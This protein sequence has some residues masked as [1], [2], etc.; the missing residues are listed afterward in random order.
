[1]RLYC[2]EASSKVEVGVQRSGACLVRRRDN[3]AG[4]TTKCGVQGTD[5]TINETT[6]TDIEQDKRRFTSVMP[7]HANESCP[8]F[9]RSYARTPQRENERST[10]TEPTQRDPKVS[11][12]VGL[13]YSVSSKST[14]GCSI[15]ALLLH[16]IVGD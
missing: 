3:E 2:L 14:S 16:I 6:N 12:D 4:W 13:L 15:L 5:K 7:S 8:Q 11:M 10:I 9:Q 1:V